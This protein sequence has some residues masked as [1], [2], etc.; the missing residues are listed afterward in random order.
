MQKYNIL[1]QQ[2]TITDLLLKEKSSKFLF[3]RHPIPI[4]YKSKQNQTSTFHFVISLPGHILSGFSTQ[5]Q[6]SKKQT[7]FMST[8]PD[9]HIPQI[10]WASKHK[11]ENIQAQENGHPDI[12]REHLHRHSLF[13]ITENID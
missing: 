6:G 10:Q 3:C 2:I 1:T 8:I 13:V 7:L 5:K 4:D 9:R 11:K 12:K